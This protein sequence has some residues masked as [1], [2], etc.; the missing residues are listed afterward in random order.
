[1]PLNGLLLP[2][3]RRQLPLYFLIGASGVTLDFLVYSLLVKGVDCHHQVANAAGYSSGT[4]LSF[5]L[6]ARFNFNTRDLLMARFASFCGVAFLGWA[7]SAGILFVTID[8]LTWN[9]YLAKLVTIAV[10]AL[11]QY[12]LNCVVSFRKQSIKRNV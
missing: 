8:H 4:I 11:L 12:N 5:A 1:M 6:N 3:R 10:V 2:L 7:S 9:K